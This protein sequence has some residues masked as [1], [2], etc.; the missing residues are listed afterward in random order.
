L[1]NEPERAS[2]ELIS[3]VRSNETLTVVSRFNSEFHRISAR[4]S[5]NLRRIAGN[6]GWLM[7]DKLLR[8]GV[9]AFVSV[10]VARYLGPELYGSLN[11]ATA[12]VALFGAFATLGLDTI[13]VSQLVRDTAAAGEMLGTAF[14]I[15]IS[16]SIVAFLLAAGTIRILEPDDS[17]ALILVSI[18]GG[19]LVFQS[20]DTVDLF[21]QAEVRS[22]LTVWAKNSAF[23]LVAVLKIVLIRMRAP[24]V[25]FAAA[26]L[27]EIVLG[28]VGLLIA[29]RASGGRLLAWRISGQRARHLLRAGWPM[30]LSTMAIM[31]Y[32]RIDTV[33]LK[34]MQGDIA[35][36]LYAA[37]VRVSEV[38]ILIPSSIVSSVSPAILRSRDNRAVYH[39]RL[40]RLFAVMTTAGLFITAAVAATSPW[41]IRILY[42]GA[43]SSASPVL[44]IHVCALAFT[45]IGMAQ[46]PWDIAENLVKLS[47]WR[48]GTGAAINIGLNLILIPKYS[49]AG[50]ALATVIS[51]AFT[52]MFGN[53][54]SRR[55]RPI[56]YMQLKSFLPWVNGIRSGSFV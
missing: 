44:A 33:M 4:F 21:F 12:F 40:R 20:F 48:H 2:S 16:G 53:L 37:A 52:A 22:R 6:A 31:T 24:L 13:I 49:A 8:I 1:Q 14:A 26:A 5:P 10:W 19:G 54:L 3:T 7:L 36:G 23:I 18:L 28:A 25:S 29:Y 38:W 55:T 35:A 39:A 50:A 9:G 41:V 51:Y 27:V 11:F 30:I 46:T 47:L 56:F 42:S 15:R 43:F 32:V 45:F 34:V 17:R